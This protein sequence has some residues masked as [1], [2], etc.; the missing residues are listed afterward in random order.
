MDVLGL[1]AFIRIA[2]CGSFRSA[3]SAMN[4]SQTALSHRIRKLEQDV[5]LSLI[6][7]TTRNVTLTRAGQE[8]FPKAR[9]MML[10][11]NR[12]YEDLKVE[13]RRASERV[14]M[15]C[16]SSLGERYLPG[17]LRTFRERHPTVNVVIYDEYAAALCDWVLA[18]EIQF[19]LTILGAQHWA[20]RAE[21]LFE[22]EF[23]AAVPVDHPLAGRAEL[24]WADLVGYPLARVATTT[25]HGFILSEGLNTFPHELD[26]RYEVQRTHMAGSLVIAGLAITV[27]PS[28]AQPRHERVRIVPITAPSISRTVGI[29][30]LSGVPLSPHALMLKRLL[31]R[32]I[33]AGRN[34]AVRGARP[35]PT[36]LAAQEPPLAGGG[37]R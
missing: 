5:G 15:G 1:E 19:A 17:A 22:E 6:Q 9:D 12:L 2:E 16:L 24:T 33:A 3:A 35:A 14:A 21:V 37:A 4:L 11:L 8:F 28:A 26:W 31:V 10:R 30:S 36:P 32:E 23:V 27:L 29:I 7:R 25:S 20:Q 13:G 34:G 18:G